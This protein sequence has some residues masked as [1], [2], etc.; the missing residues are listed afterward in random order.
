MY[1]RSSE[2][3]LGDIFSQ[4]KTLARDLGKENPTINIT[5]DKFRATP[6]GGKLLNNIFTHLIRNSMDHGIESD[7]ERLRSGKT[8]KGELSIESKLTDSHLIIRFRDDGAGLRL[9]RIKK[10]G[11]AKNLIKHEIEDSHLIASLIFHHG[12]STTDSVTEISGRGVGMGAIKEYLESTGGS[13]GI[14]FL[15]N[16][17]NR[18]TIP[19]E[20]EVTVPSQLFVEGESG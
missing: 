14:K 13:I 2:D 8:P 12:F 17:G 19:F 5:G 18:D 10:I 11:I 15:D 1:F 3:I 9:N 4:V 16:S 6:D 20:F 7:S